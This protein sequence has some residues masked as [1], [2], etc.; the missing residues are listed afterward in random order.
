MV[1]IR[2]LAAQCLVGAVVASYSAECGML[3][4]TE[5][6]HIYHGPVSS[7]VRVDMAH[8]RLAAFVKDFDT[9]QQLISQTRAMNLNL[10][11]STCH[12][13]VGRPVSKIKLDTEVSQAYLYIFIYITP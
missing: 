11:N 7:A 12:G 2:D 5:I 3:A 4:N 10:Q 1:Q 8:F 6:G 9:N 13:K